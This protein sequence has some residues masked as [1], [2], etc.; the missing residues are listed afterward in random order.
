MIPKGHP[1]SGKIMLKRYK[2]WPF[3]R[4]AALT[5]DS[6]TFRFRAQAVRAKLNKFKTKEGR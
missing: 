6:R 3:F 1:F 4:F 5:A 2:P